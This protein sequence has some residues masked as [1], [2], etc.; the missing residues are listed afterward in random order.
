MPFKNGE[1]NV[2]SNS[3]RI[4]I[5]GVLPIGLDAKA[6]DG[7]NPIFTTRLIEDG[8]DE[9]GKPF[10]RTE[11]YKFDSVKEANNFNDKVNNPALGLQKQALFQNKDNI[12]ATGS[13]KPGEKNFEFTENASDIDKKFTERIYTVQR[14]K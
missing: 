2:L 5:G 3:A 6:V 10:Y 13:T 4:R 14:D 11:V 9:K 1:N 12:I 7:Y 8:F